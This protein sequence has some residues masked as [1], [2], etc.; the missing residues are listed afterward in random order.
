MTLND[1]LLILS[2]LLGP[3]IAVQAQKWIERSRAGDERRLQIF[4]SLMATR[5]ATLSQQHVHALNM[6]SLEFVGAKYEAVRTGWKIYLDHLG[7]YPEAADE[8]ASKSWHD[9]RAT[10][11]GD[12]LITMSKTFGYKFDQVDMAKGIYS[13]KGHTELELENDRLRRALLAWVDGG[14]SVKMEVT[15]FPASPQV[16]SEG[17]ELRRL[18]IE[19]LNGERAL[20]VRQSDG[21]QSV[22]PGGQ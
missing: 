3:V 7:S 11:L 9:K 19:V 2:T 15:A 10:Y 8:S 17:A 1:G 5:A 12:L 4:K 22:L 16:A 18:L 6:I 13:P 14:H 21:A 20:P